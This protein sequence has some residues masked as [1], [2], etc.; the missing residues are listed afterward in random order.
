MIFPFL[1][2]IL[3]FRKAPVTWLLFFVNLFVFV[4]TF[5]ESQTSQQKIESYLHDETFSEAQ[6]YVFAQF[7]DE[8]RSRYPA[9]LQYLAL[10]SQLESHPDRR[11]VLGA[12]ALRDKLFMQEASQFDFHGD[13]VMI[14][15][16]REQFSK[17][18]LE[19]DAHPSYNMGVTDQ[20]SDWT[21][22]ITYQFSHSGWS[23]LVGNMIFFMLFAGH[24]ELLIGGVGLI[25]VY[26]AS[27]IIA[28]L[29][30]LTVN[31]ATA[32]PL[33]GAS[34]AVS[35]LMALFCVLLWNRGVKYLFFLF[36]P[37]R[38]FAGIIY[39][40]AWVTLIMWMLS[41]LAG[42]WSSIA[43]FGG[44][45]YTAHLGGELCGVLIGL[46]LVAMRKM[47]H[48]PRVPNTIETKP[49]FTAYV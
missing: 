22:W 17:I 8:N 26:L 35:G 48:Q 2:G 13:K 24:L 31:E 18:L 33:I 25:V 41:D 32:I 44:I 43:E 20:K 34:G 47:R 15:W 40:P 12:M 4:Y 5:T 37:K 19:R 1:E 38:G 39:L 28:A 3:S 7:I 27:G 21:Q 49:V 46:T 11:I 6:G 10:R 9:S 14:G 36:V 42:H 16:W 30:F 45:A 29:V 23:H